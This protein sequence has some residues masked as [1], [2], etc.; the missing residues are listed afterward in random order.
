M[1]EITKITTIAIA[2]TTQYGQMAFR[3]AIS[4]YVR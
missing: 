4:M 1:I 2:E 3:T